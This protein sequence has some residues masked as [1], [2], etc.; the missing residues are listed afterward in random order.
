MAVQHL[1]S[2]RVIELT[3][4]NIFIKFI[5]ITRLLKPGLTIL[6]LLKLLHGYSQCSAIRQ[7]RDISFDTDKDCAPVTVTNFTI[8]YYF[9]VAQ[10]PDDITIRF[11]WNDPTDH[12]D[13]YGVGDPGFNN[14]G[15]VEFT[16]TGTFN[17]LANNDCSFQPVASLWVGGTECETSRQ[18]QIVTSW[19][20]DN[21]FGGTLSIDPNPYD[22]CFYNP[23]VNAV[24]EDNSTFNCNPNQEPDNPNRL[25]RHTQFVYGTN[26]NP[27]N[28]IRNLTLVD[29][30]GNTVVLTDG[31][32]NLVAGP[33]FGPLDTIPFPADGPN[34][35]SF[36]ISAPADSAN[37]IGFEF[38]ITLYNWNICNPYNG[39][40]ASPN[41]N[42][43]VSTTAYIRIV[44]PPEPDFQTRLGDVSGDIQTVF[45]LGETI[46][47][48]NLTPGNFGYT[49]EFYDDP[50][51]TG[52]FST[53]TT[54]NPTYVYNTPGD[55]LIRLTASNANAQG[56]CEVI[57]EDI[58]TLSPAA[59]AAIGTFDAAFSN[60]V[61]PDFC[62]DG[63]NPVTVG[64]R[65]ETTN[66]EPDTEWR[67]EF[68]NENNVLEASAPPGPG[69][70]SAVPITNFTRNYTTQ[71][72]Y[73]VRLIARNNLTG[74]E[75]M[76][77]VTIRV[78]D[79]PG[80]A[81]NFTQ[82]CAGER[83]FFSGIPDSVAALDPRIN[84][85]FVSLYEWDLSYDGAF[86]PDLTSTANAD[87]LFY[88]DGNDIAGGVEPATSVAGT[89]D[90]ALR[91]TTDSGSCS[92]VVVQQVVVHPL[93]VPELSSDYSQP[94]CP[95]ETVNFMNLS[96]LN[97]ADYQLVITD[98]LT[99]YDT[100]DFNRSDAAYLFPNTTSASRFFYVSL[101]ASTT[102]SCDSTTT[103]LT[104]EILPSSG[105]GFEDLNY[106]LTTGNCSVWES[107]LRTDNA[108]QALDPDRYT[109]IISDE[110]GVLPGYPAV[111]NNGDPDFH[112]LDYTIVNETGQNRLYTVNLEVEKTGICVAGSQRNFIINPK[113]AGDFEMTVT[114]S[115]TYKTIFLEATQ[116]GLSGYHWEFDPAPDQFLNDE[117]EQTL[118]YS[119]PSVNSPDVPLSFRLV[120]EN[121]A[122]CTSDTVLLQTSLEALEAPIIADFTVDPDTIY[123]PENTTVIQN[124]SSNDP[125]LSYFWDF[126]DGF[127]STIYSP[128]VH[129]YNEPGNYLVSLHV[130]NRFCYEEAS[131]TVVV[132]P[133]DPTIDFEADDTEGCNP[134]TVHFTNTSE[135]A[136]SGTYLWDFG[137]GST[138]TLDEPS[139]A[140]IRPG[141]Y[142]V[143][144]YGENGIGRGAE[145]IK[146]AYIHVYPQP[147]ASFSLNP[148]TV[149][150]PDQLVYFRNSTEDAT[151][152]RWDFGDGNTSEEE[153]PTHF[154]ES[155]GAYDITLIASNEFN[156][157]DTLTLFAAVEAVVGGEIQTP[158]AFSPG[159]REF[160]D[161][162]NDVFIPKVEGVTEFRMLIYNKWGELLFESTNHTVGWDGYYRGLLQ[163]SDVYVYKLELTYSDG[164]KAVK[165]GDV[166]LVR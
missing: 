4:V 100:L 153:N 92:A 21:G 52:P 20:R 134:L 137:D 142:T 50:T 78:Y 2:V 112:E 59:I 65:D 111:K 69:T 15:N 161:A 119:R 96:D 38:E 145:A 149:Y 40:A 117:D 32:A 162:V 132:M 123:L 148:R 34:M 150:L 77:S 101:A 76:D 46:Y 109:W 140:Y 19:A 113:P 95:D 39:N 29:D 158:N 147:V 74:C 164:R 90:V 154:Y 125:G 104:V 118:I 64:F 54:E 98:S 10:D 122:G 93:P 143:R 128:G 17:Y 68:F 28:S 5:I 94:L 127:S 99:L 23:I 3:Y 166:T 136:A 12:V 14:V 53:S 73:L 130:S 159:G 129:T 18:T 152:Y 86:N 135:F 36:P 51:G 163:P 91:M 63:S 41:Y 47:F 146:E 58:V 110:N 42:E 60:P 72:E 87:F 8:T 35:Q 7:Q 81:F 124:N 102:E 114:D 45:C 157:A 55:K 165:V 11:E 75:T 71:G 62:G 83:T 105:S 84:N 89:Y 88:L 48:E 24:F 160:G 151:S 44:A 133:A 156:C 61:T 22:V 121:L 27:A 97:F 138:S 155:V 26:H 56:D 126:G 139:H 131:R 141:E 144:L 37:D 16:A 49:W 80:P 57:Y 85:D 82:V 67:W 115:C 107:T 43:A 120:G 6:L 103:P 25:A 30:L 66:V 106:T 79:T 13:I 108:T 1:A 9:N 33:Y 70:T 31:N 116:K